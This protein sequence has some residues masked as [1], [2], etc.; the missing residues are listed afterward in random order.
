M[1]R[2]IESSIFYWNLLQF[3]RIYNWMV[4]TRVKV[5]LTKPQ[6]LYWTYFSA[7]QIS[8]QWVHFI[9]QKFFFRF[10]YEPWHESMKSLLSYNNTLEI[11]LACFTGQYCQISEKNWFVH[12]IYVNE[13]LRDFVLKSWNSESINT[14]DLMLL[15]II[16]FISQP[17]WK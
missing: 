17:E 8:S 11:E 7:K 10:V 6:N 1:I 13:K 4:I 14:F 3:G 15:K 16:A 12:S 2:N 9:D 5:Q